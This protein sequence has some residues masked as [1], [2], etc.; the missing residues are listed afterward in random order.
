MSGGRVVSVSA[1]QSQI[2]TDITN[3]AADGVAVTTVS[4]TVKNTD[5][6]GGEPN[7]MSG[8]RGSAVVLAVT[9]STG[10][11]ITQP[12]GTANA[13]GA[14]TG[15][16]VSTNAATVSVTAT[17]LGQ[18]VTGGA[19]VVVGGG[20]PAPPDPGD[21]FF[22]DDFA[23]AQRNNANGFTWSSAG[24]RVTVVTFDGG[25]CLRFRYGPD[26]SGSDSSAEQRFNMGQDLSEVWIEYNLHIPSNFALRND[27][28]ANNK[29]L[30]LWPTNY[31]S[32]GDTYV[33]TEFSRNGTDTSNARMLGLGD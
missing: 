7:A 22:S 24:G 17:V 19:T 8:L 21:P 1:G 11:T 31:S 15:S 16:F 9:P 6:T 26:A 33:V 30:S 29:F 14:V 4:V 12:I 5:N 10:V 13:S 2:S 25:N 20:D 18:A 23:G 3:P 32:T 27:S 28:P